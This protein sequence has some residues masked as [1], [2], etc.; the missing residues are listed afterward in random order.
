MTTDASNAEITRCDANDDWTAWKIGSKSDC[1]AVFTAENADQYAEL[2]SIAMRLCKSLDC[3]LTTQAEELISADESKRYTAGDVRCYISRAFSDCLF[4]CS[5]EM[6]D[7]LLEG[8]IEDALEQHVPSSGGNT[9][10]QE[11]AE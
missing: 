1:R 3:W 9:K 2:V 11:D 5:N 6:G 7:Q 4:E 8:Y 10:E